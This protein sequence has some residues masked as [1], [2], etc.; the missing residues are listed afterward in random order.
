MESY[1]FVIAHCKAPVRQNG[2]KDQVFGMEMTRDRL[3]Q[4][5]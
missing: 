2:R 5:V 3:Q 1:D 4:G